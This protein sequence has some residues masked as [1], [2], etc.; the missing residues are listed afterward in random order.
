MQTSATGLRL[1]AGASRPAGPGTVWV[2]PVVVIARAAHCT[3]VVR[4]LSVVRGALP[5]HS[6]D[7]AGRMRAR[8]DQADE[9]ESRG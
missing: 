1:V 8:H 7:E 2:L 6:S 3:G 5:R 4:V 9:K